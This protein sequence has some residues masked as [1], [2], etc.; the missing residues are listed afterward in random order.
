MATTKRKPETRKSAEEGLSPADSGDEYEERTPEPSKTRGKKRARTAKMTAKDKQQEKRRKKANLSM[1][2]EMPIDILYEI[3]SLVHPRDLLHISWTAKVLNGFLTSK[4]SR[5]VWQASFKTVPENEQPPPCPPE[6]TEMAYAN[7]VYGQC[8]MNCSNTHPT[9]PAWRA[10]VRVCGHCVEEIAIDRVSARPDGLPYTT[11]MSD[12]L[13]VF[14]VNYR[15]Q[16][17]IEKVLRS[18]SERFSEE[19]AAVGNSS[20]EDVIKKY[21]LLVRQRQE[22]SDAMSKLKRSAEKAKED[23][24]VDV[25]ER[26]IE[27]IWEKL[28]EEGWH[29]EIATRKSMYKPGLLEIKGVVMTRPLGEKAWAELR[30]PLN[31]FMRDESKR[32][33]ARLT[34]ARCRSR[35]D[36]VRKIVDSLH[37]SLPHPHDFY[38]SAADI[39]WI[40]EVRKT[41][42]DGT[43]K[44]FQD[45]EADIRSRI[46]ELSAAWLEE[47]R[48]VF[49]QLLPQD[50]PSLEHLSLATTLFDCMKCRKFGMRIEEALSHC[51]RYYY[52][53]KFIAQFSNVASASVYHDV[54]APWDSG[55]A[56]YQYST[57]LSALVREVVFECG[58]NPDTITTKEM[59][60]KHHRFARFGTDGTIAVLN[61]F[62]AVSFQ[63]LFIR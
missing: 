61:W 53:D 47:R 19:L 54:G 15:H 49:L 13:P 18:D 29:E 31:K 50:S 7:L 8:C 60:R 10:L 30:D 42:V 11:N 52:G 36:E 34:A 4:S 56:E 51:C 5:H 45:C 27:R 37:L 23:A 44:E 25:R 6:M 33:H 16:G 35:T 9:I 21:Q 41:I 58:E 38:P 17:V 55:L 57:T 43:D 1:L 40:P 62:Q 14:R 20:Q 12:I 2:P 3:F 46:P 22:F 59:N 28:S 32:I 48:K 39:C 26:R 63:N 24:R